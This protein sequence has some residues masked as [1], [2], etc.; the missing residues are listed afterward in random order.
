V[1]KPSTININEKA[2]LKFIEV[3]APFFSKLSLHFDNELI[4]DFSFKSDEKNLIKTNMKNY[5]SLMNTLKKLN[6]KIDSKYL[7]TFI[8]L[9]ESYKENNNQKN[10][11]FSP[12]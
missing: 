3:D 7:N 12:M 5:D 8:I 6:K 4:S 10:G 11:N 9:I 2:T 1:F